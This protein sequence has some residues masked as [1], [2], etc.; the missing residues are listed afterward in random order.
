MS[1]PIPDSLELRD[2][3]L[4]LRPY[5]G[6]DAGALFAAVH[7]SIESVG[8]W[9]PWCHADYGEADAQSW[10]AHCAEGWRTGEHYTF[11]VF[12]ADTAQ[13]CGAVG[14]NQRNRAQNFMNLGYWIRASRQ[15]QGVVRRAARLAAGFGFGHLGL[16]RIEIV[17]MSDNLASQKV[18]VALGAMF[19][20]I[21][22]NRIVAH[23]RAHD[24]LVYSLIPPATEPARSG[25]AHI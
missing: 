16:T 25:D 14:L 24:G 13:F 19:E 20:G 23:G 12:D 8:R 18:A 6:E 4:T 9:L 1:E 21:A 10:I 11:A 5:R 17:T 22:R 15:G 2:A 3:V 7:E